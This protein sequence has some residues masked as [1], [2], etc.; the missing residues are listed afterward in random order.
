MAS[1]RKQTSLIRKRK[2]AKAGNK[3]KAKLR[4]QGTT[5]TA[6][7]LF[8]DEEQAETFKIL[9]LAIGE[10]MQMIRL[11]AF[12]PLPTEKQASRFPSDPCVSF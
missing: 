2:A 3:R 9:S 7:Q 8:G 1:T 5:T 10:S 11:F 12:Q 6:A 4:N